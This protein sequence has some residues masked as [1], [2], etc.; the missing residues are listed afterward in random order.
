MSQKRSPAARANL[1]M[2]RFISSHRHG[3]MATW[4]AGGARKYLAAFDHSSADGRYNGEHELLARLASPQAWV[5]I[6]CGAHVGAWALMARSSFPQA[7]I[8]AIEPVAE[9]VHQLRT[10]VGADTGIFVHAIALSDRIGTAEMVVDDRDRATASLTTAL[11][12]S[13]RRHVAVAVTT[14]DAF[15]TEHT[16]DHV[17][18]LKIDAEGHDLAV[19]RGFGAALA[20]QA[21]DVVQFEVSGWNAVSRTWVGEFYE[22][23]E[24][25]GYLV[26]RVV[27]G[28]VTLGAYR[29]T[30]EDFSKT[31]NYVAVRAAL[32]DVVAAVAGA[33]RS[34]S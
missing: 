5:V 13:A 24:A 18:L 11:V 27:P 22:L 9:T 3:R 15:L 30:F 14:G 25:G 19:V 16:V 32:P 6:D 31:Q 17:H 28:G 33:Y 29:S 1:V 20:R 34:A 26:G 4:F 7:T 23:L 12:D 8:H 2:Y 21:I 10:A